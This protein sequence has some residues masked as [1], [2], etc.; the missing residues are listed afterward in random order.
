MRTFSKTPTR[1][2][3][4]PFLFKVGTLSQECFHGSADKPLKLGEVV[5]VGDGRR[6]RVQVRVTEIRGDD[7]P[8][9]FAER[10]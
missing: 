1:K 9:Y 4:V 3:P 8:L 6:N 2:C 5:Q 7:P 10:W